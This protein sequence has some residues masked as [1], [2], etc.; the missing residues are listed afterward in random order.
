LIEP[1]MLIATNFGL[2]ATVED[3]TVVK[4]PD[5]AYAPQIDPLPAGQTRRSYTPYLQGSPV[6]VVKSC[7]RSA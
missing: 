5:W 7:D 4:A 3:R 6:A 1:N 2:C